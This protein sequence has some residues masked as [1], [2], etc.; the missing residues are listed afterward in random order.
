MF[1]RRPLDRPVEPAR[2]LTAGR[3][4]LEIAGGSVVGH[5]YPENYDVLHVDPEL[6]LAVVCDGMGDGEGSRIA[7]T[8]AAETFVARVRA[9]WP[10]VGPTGLRSPA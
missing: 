3:L 10:A 7:G 4:T 9:D 8:T 1:R 6:P 2:R 5:R